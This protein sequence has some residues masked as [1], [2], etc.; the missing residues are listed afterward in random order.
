MR[1]ASARA[2]ERSPSAAHSANRVRTAPPKDF[3]SAIRRA[4]RAA[5]PSRPALPQPAA[6]A[7]RGMS[8]WRGRTRTSAA[9]TERPAC[10]ALPPTSSA[11]H[12]GPARRRHAARRRAPAA[13]SAK[14][15]CR[16]RTLPPV[17]S[18]ARY[19][20]TVSRPTASVSPKAPAESAKRRPPAMPTIA[21]AAA[22][23]TPASRAMTRPSAA[24][25]GRRAPT[26]KQ[27]VGYAF[28]YP[29]TAVRAR[30][31]EAAAQ[32]PAR[33]AASAT[34]AFPAPIPRNAATAAWSVRTAPPTWGDQQVVP[35]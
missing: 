8:A 28:R 15:A 13:V 3:R 1:P 2:V 35:R 22:S 26:A 23:A 33:G 10:I 29:R 17:A 30:W 34:P 19:A 32:R 9:W 27:R 7:A 31:R 4:T 20:A 18:E 25:V 11:P 16:E 21:P 24:P 6:G 12:S 5:T 14:R